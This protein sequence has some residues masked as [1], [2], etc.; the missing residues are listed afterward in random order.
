MPKRPVPSD[1]STS[2]EVPPVS[3]ISKSWMIAAPLVAMADT[4]PRSIRSASTGPRPVLI[5][6]APIPQT[7]PPPDRF[8]STIAET[9]ARKSAAASN[10]GRESRNPANPAPAS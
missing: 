4:K 8:A 3:A 2:S 7:T 6:C 10:D 5:T 9:T 1:S